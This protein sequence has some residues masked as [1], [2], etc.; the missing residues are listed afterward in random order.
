M[1]NRGHIEQVT[2]TF[3]APPESGGER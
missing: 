2:A 1:L 3:T